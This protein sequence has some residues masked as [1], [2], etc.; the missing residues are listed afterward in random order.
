MVFTFSHQTTTPHA[1]HSSDLATVLIIIIVMTSIG[2]AF[3]YV[4]H[5]KKK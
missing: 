1:L 2:F 5:N 3:A 4:K